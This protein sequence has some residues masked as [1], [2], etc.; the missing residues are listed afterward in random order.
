MFYLTSENVAWLCN[1]NL[2]FR[3]WCLFEYHKYH[4]NW[5]NMKSNDSTVFTA[6]IKEQEKLYSWFDTMTIS[7]NDQQIIA[8]QREFYSSNLNQTSLV[9]HS[10][11]ISQ[12]PEL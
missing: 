4:E 9:T 11:L 6:K 2:L 8:N 7:D 12:I 1:P 10:V 3:G 5:T